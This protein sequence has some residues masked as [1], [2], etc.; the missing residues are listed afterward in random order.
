V[1]AVTLTLAAGW[2][3]SIRKKQDQGKD[4]GKV[5][6]YVHCGAINQNQ[7]VLRKR[8]SASSFSIFS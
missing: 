2:I 8:Q 6:T 7:D 3:F 4:Q 1:S 5:L